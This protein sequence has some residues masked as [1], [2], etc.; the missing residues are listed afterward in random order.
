MLAPL[1]QVLYFAGFYKYRPLMPASAYAFLAGHA[2]VSLLALAWARRAPGSYVACRE[3]LASTAKMLSVV[4]PIR[5]VGGW[6][7]A[8]RCSIW[9]PMRRAARAGGQHTQDALYCGFHGVCVG[10]G[11]GRWGWEVKAIVGGDMGGYTGCLCGDEFNVG[12]GQ[13][14]RS[15]RLWVGWGTGPQALQVSLYS[16]WGLHC[17]PFPCTALPAAELPPTLSPP[18]CR[19][20]LR[21]LSLAPEAD[22]ACPFPAL[23]QLDGH[24]HRCYRGP[25]EPEPGAGA[26]AHVLCDLW[27][28][29]GFGGAGPAGHA[30]AAG[31]A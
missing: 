24:L 29:D 7:W 14:G 18:R 28:L 9:G 25:A 17:L 11:A 22:S 26:D 16:S 5:C 4:D 2:A 23:P 1:M 21:Q 3:A 10:G 31:E 20:V 15:G 13:R 19:R 27:Q 6:G 30:A 8:D 12:Q